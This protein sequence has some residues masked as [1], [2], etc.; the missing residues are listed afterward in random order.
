MIER[1]D[2]PRLLFEPRAAARVRCDCR[3]EHLQRHAAPE[4]RIFG[5]VDLAHPAG[6]ERR[7]DFVG[8]ETHAGSEGQAADYKG[9]A[10]I[11]AGL[12]LQ[13]IWREAREFADG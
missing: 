10:V 3:L 2:R 7:K 13:P 8:T 11:R 4:P 5:L 9:A 1:G 12:L 6:A